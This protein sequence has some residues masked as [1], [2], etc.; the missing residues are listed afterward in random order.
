MI[1]EADLMRELVSVFVDF[2]SSIFYFV[3]TFGLI[4]KVFRE[5]G[6][7]IGLILS[8]GFMSGRF[9]NFRVEFFLVSHFVQDFIFS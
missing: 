4:K 5:G 9:F 7:M 3:F 8:F 1:L 6:I 2:L